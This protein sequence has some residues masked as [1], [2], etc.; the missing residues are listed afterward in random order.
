MKRRI[1]LAAVF[2]LLA[3]AARGQEKKKTPEPPR[4]GPEVEKLGY[5]V[6][7]WTSAGEMKPS[8]MGPGGKTYGHD[9]CAWMSGN[10]FVACNMGSRSPVGA[11]MALGIMG[12]DAEK[13]VYTWWSFNSAG[14]VETATGVLENGTWTW[15][16]DMRMGDRMVKARYVVTDTA[17]EG[18]A[19]RWETSED[20]KG[21]N[22][23]LQGK[24]SKTEE[25]KN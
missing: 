12:F 25:A 11:R 4:P 5:F 9:R 10:F 22:T 8:S 7:E 19:F 3:A 13:K 20:G 1:V 23:L 15:S 17:P 14:A 24:V 16:N 18:Y 21:W 6:G 2:G